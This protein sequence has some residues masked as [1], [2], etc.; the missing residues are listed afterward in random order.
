[1][2][3]SKYVENGFSSIAKKYDLFN[4][5]VTLGLHRSWKKH[6]A[7]KVLNER[8]RKVLDACCGSGDIAIEIDR[9]AKK[10]SIETEITGIDFSEKMLEIARNKSE[11]GRIDFTHKDVMESGF[12]DGYFDSISIGFG[13]RNIIGLHQSLIEFH[14]LLS[15]GGKLVILD[16]GKPP[17]K[18]VRVMFEFTFFKLVPKIGKLLLPKQDMFDYFPQ[19]TLKYP[20]QEELVLILKE[21]GYTDITYRNYLFGSVVI[22]EAIKS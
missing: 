14:R 15:N 10:Q 13:L 17:S 12:Q 2:A 22:H 20:E 7:Q 4:D 5:I 8:P 18:I 21:S 16:M 9:Q 1:M 6:V 11:K 19:S 3:N